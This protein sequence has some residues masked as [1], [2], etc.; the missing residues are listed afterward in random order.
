V[1]ASQTDFAEHHDGFCDA[2][3]GDGSQRYRNR[4]VAMVRTGLFEMTKIQAIAATRSRS[5]SSI[6]A[7][8][9]GKSP[10]LRSARPAVTS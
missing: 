1:P 7:K 4:M 3:R 6:E 2:V 9:A 8:A 10:S 5:R